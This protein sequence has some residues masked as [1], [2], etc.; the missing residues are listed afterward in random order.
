MPV[1]KNQL[2]AKIVVRND[3]AA[4]WSTINP[5]LL[6]GEV[7]LEKDTNKFKF[8]DGVKKWSELPYAGTQVKIQGEGEVLTGAEINAA[9]ELVLI[10][11][12]FDLTLIH[13]LNRHNIQSAT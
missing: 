6:A 8:G 10:Y 3:L 2:K 13:C 7:G 5:V 12:G 4:Q 11:I 9:G 1:E